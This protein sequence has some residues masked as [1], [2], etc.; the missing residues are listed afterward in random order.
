MAH[1]KKEM[2]RK[3]LAVHPRLP[4]TDSSRKE[5]ALNT[6]SFMKGHQCWNISLMKVLYVGTKD[7]EHQSLKSRGI[8]IT[9]RRRPC[10]R[11]GHLSSCILIRTELPRLR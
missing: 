5:R 7:Q 10:R 6:L 4:S 9:K 8:P 11:G 2:C 3:G 1:L